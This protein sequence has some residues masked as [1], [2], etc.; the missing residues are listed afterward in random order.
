MSRIVRPL[1]YPQDGLW[2]CNMVDRDGRVWGEA[3]ADSRALVIQLA[4]K[5]M[6]ER[7]RIR[8]T[9][10][11]VTRHP[12]I[13]GA[14]AGAVVMYYNASRNN[15]NYGVRDYLTGAAVLGGTC[16]IVSKVVKIV[17]H[18]IGY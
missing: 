2:K 13:G 8:K 12:F 6:P 14:A 10:G 17:K 18:M 15:M 16:W 5:E 3:S 7:G 9:L 11:W 1:V 4:R